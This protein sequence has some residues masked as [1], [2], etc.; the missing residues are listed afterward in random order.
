MQ[1][2]LLVLGL[3]ASQ[4]AFAEREISCWNQYARRG[5]PPTIRAEIGPDNRL[6]NIRIN[7][8]DVTFQDYVY[9]RTSNYS[10]RSITTSTV[11]DPRGPVEALEITT[12]RSPYK[13]NNEYVFDFGTWEVT[14]YRE[15][16]T[17]PFYH[18]T[19]T[20]SGRWIL[21]KDL[22]NEF[23]RNYRIRTPNER[24]N[25]LIVMGPPRDSNQGGSNYLR[26]F[27][28]SR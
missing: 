8:Q 19:G 6:E 4:S 2:A 9:N 25:S 27:C 16:A 10:G 23:L 28:T 18:D 20:Y 21:P 11:T 13:G 15:H 26:M 3:L 12:N 22:S 1:K 7:A 5:S 14:H 17:R 24:S